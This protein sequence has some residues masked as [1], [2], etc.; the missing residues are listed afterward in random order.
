MRFVPC[1]TITT[2]KRSSDWLSPQHFHTDMLA[3]EH[4]LHAA[5][6]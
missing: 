5:H 3:Q 4:D 2:A 6:M 1:V